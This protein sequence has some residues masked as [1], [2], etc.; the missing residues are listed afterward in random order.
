MGKNIKM[1]KIYHKVLRN[2][3]E[4]I[5]LVI[6]RMYAKNFYT[7]DFKYL[8]EKDIKNLII[9]ID[10]TILPADDV[11]VPNVLMEKVRLLKENGFNICLVS[12]NK[13]ARVEPVAKL[14]NVK[15]LYEA[16][17]P[18][19]ECYDKALEILD[20]SDLTKIAM[21]GDQMLT[22]IYGANTYGIYSILV[23]PIS[24]KNNI[25]TFINRCLQN[26]VEKHLKKKNLFDNER[27]YIGD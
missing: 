13:K 15:Y 14:L 9:D 25:G 8:L 20:T 18:L 17:K 26:R 24:K 27:Y 12:N 23:K 19:K 5:K 10:G 6:P 11:N 4:E 1:L 21:I 22:D 16:K 3:Q 2:N 7:I